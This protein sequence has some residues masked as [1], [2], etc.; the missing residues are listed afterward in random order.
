[1]LPTFNRLQ[2]EKL[3]FIL[4]PYAK[5]WTLRAIWSRLPYLIIS[6]LVI[7]SKLWNY[8]QILGC[9]IITLGVFHNWDTTTVH[10]HILCQ[11]FSLF[12]QLLLADSMNPQWVPRETVVRGLPLPL[13]LFLMKSHTKA[14]ECASCSQPST[15]FS[16]RTVNN[17]ARH[18]WSVPICRRAAEAVHTR[19]M[20]HPFPVRECD[21]I[22]LVHIHAHCVP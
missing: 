18:A 19:H 16:Q 17:L 15:P 1:M 13:L 11:V 22:K 5:Y 7:S 14:W 2:S 4:L 3:Y 8:M 6:S 20:L 9:I 21:L 12:F 10:T